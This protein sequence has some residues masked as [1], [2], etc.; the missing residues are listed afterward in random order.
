[1]RQ[2]VAG[3]IYIFLAGSIW[4]TTGIFVK[5]LAARGLAATE[6]TFMRGTVLLPALAA[7]AWLTNRRLL[8]VDRRDVPRFLLI[9]LLSFGLAQPLF[10][11]T[12]TV[13]NVAIAVLLNYTAPVFVTILS[14]VLFSEPL[15]GR[16]MTAL[17]LVMVGLCMVT[18]VYRASMAVSYTG[19]LTGLLSGFFYAAYTVALKPI[20][21]RYH[22]VT[23]LVWAAV[24]GTPVLGIVHGLTGG[25]LFSGYTPAV[26]ALLIVAAL[27]PGTLAFICFAKGVALAEASK[28]AIVATVEPVVAS[29]LAFLLYSETLDPVQLVGMSMILAGIIVVSRTKE[30]PARLV[31]SHEAQEV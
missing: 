12:L 11:Y 1:M 16:K 7:G 9:G 24:F 10:L 29:I 27:F 14:R 4:G 21:A 18:G 22:P 5:E 13:T 20:S 28:A 23:L 30:T 3:Y 15:T 19:L 26:W 6:I 8:Q 2:D 17:G 31:G 25:S